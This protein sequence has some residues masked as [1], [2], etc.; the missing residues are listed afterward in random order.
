M[1]KCLRRV[2]ARAASSTA[3][4]RRQMYLCTPPWRTAQLITQ[5]NGYTRCYSLAAV[6]PTSPFILAWANFSCQCPSWSMLRQTSSSSSVSPH[7]PWARRIHSDRRRVI[8]SIAGCCSMPAIVSLS[9]NLWIVH[10]GC[11]SFPIQRL[12]ILPRLRI[13]SSTADDILVLKR[14]DESSLRKDEKWYDKREREEGKKKDFEP[15]AM[16]KKMRWI[17]GCG[18]AMIKLRDFRRLR[19]TMKRQANEMREASDETSGNVLE[20]MTKC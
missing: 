14:D 8:L 17:Y 15:R 9:V 18:C 12:Q 19:E 6:I 11:I 3:V 5:G 16:F 2:S 10:A 4:W 20:S 13:H 1:S 7:S